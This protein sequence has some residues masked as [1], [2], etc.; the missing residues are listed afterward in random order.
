MI[1]KVVSSCNTWY[2]TEISQEGSSASLWVK[3]FP[4]KSCEHANQW[5]GWADQQIQRAE[6]TSVF[7]KWQRT[8]TS[9]FTAVFISCYTS[10][11]WYSSPESGRWGWSYCWTDVSPCSPGRTSLFNLECSFWWN[12]SCALE[13]LRHYKGP[14]CMSLQFGARVPN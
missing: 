2:A 4:V 13:Y 9:Q 5:Q 11:D 6:F 1:N 7:D 8:R 10:R 12:G 14:A 3:L